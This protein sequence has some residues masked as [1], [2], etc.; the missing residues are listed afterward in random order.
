MKKVIDYSIAILF[1]SSL[2]GIGFTG[3][4]FAYLATAKLIG[5]LIW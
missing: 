1:F 3:G 2:A 4:C 5:K